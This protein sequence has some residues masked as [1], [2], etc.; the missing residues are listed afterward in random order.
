MVSGALM[1]IPRGDFDALN[2]FGTVSAAGL[3]GTWKL[4]IVQRTGGPAIATPSDAVYT[5]TVLDGSTLSA[6]ADCNTCSGSFT[7]VGDVIT[8]SPVLACTRALCPTS[9][10]ETIYESLLDQ[11]GVHLHPALGVSG[12][13]DTGHGLLLSMSG[14]DVP[15]ALR[16]W[17]VRCGGAAGVS[18]PD[19][20]DLCT[21]LYAQRSGV[22][23][24]EF[25]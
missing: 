5:L 4:Q 13:I 22:A 15:A 23:P 11:D 6:H 14:L 20:R 19:F 25:R 9:T 24:P 17:W 10:I 21:A 16:W 7:I 18:T 12:R 1:L 2:G 3:A 8:V